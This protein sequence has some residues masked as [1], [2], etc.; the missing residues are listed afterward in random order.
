MRT[1]GCALALVAVLAGCGQKTV[2]EI[3]GTNNSVAITISTK[4]DKD[5]AIAP[6]TSVS[7]GSAT[8]SGTSAIKGAQ[9]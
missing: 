5:L 3:P 7:Q 9:P 2:I 6:A 8:A 1:I 4:E